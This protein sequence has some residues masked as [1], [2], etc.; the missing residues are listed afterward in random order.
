MDNS[1][2]QLGRRL[3]LDWARM[4]E[5]AHNDI[6]TLSLQNNLEI[7]ALKK[8]FCEERASSSIAEDTDHEECFYAAMDEV[9]TQY[10]I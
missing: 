9:G 3:Y 10:W 8:G 5:D 7:E 6:R 4:E 2:I 1:Q